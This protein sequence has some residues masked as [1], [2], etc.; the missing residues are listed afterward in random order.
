MISF[1]DRLTWHAKRLRHRRVAARVLATP[2]IRQVDDGVV[3]L[4]MVG[5]A[6][7]LPALVA[8][9][10]LHAQLGR[11]RVALL[12]DGSLTPADRATFAHHLG[13]PAITHIRDVDLGA[14][15][16]GGTWERLLHLLDLRRDQYVIQVDSDTVTLGALPEV[17]QAIDAGRDFTLRGEA[18]AALVEVEALRDRYRGSDPR[19][20]G[21]HV[22]DAAEEAM[23]QVAIA[24]GALRRYARGCSGFAGFA[25][26][27]PGR[28]LAEGFS[29]EMDRLIGRERWSRWGSEQ[30]TSNLVVANGSD[31]LLLPYDRYCNFED[32]PLP[33]DMR[34]VHFIGTCRFHGSAYRDAT[35]ASIAALGH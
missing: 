7:V 20:P 16:P 22:Q 31:P 33:A 1:A 21:L 13:N 14:A 4:S 35:R 12:D 15:P 23:G 24:G 26:G 18:E 27:G 30:V 29:L 2:P 25:P 10:S 6:V 19:R 11:G 9:K 28:T 34:F 8:I 3:L 32:R 17:E 5:S